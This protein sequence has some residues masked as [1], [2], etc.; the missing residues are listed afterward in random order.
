MRIERRVK[1]FLIVIGM[2]MANSA[3]SQTGLI[4]TTYAATALEL[5]KT[6][7]VLTKGQIAKLKVNNAKGKVGWKTS[8]ERIATVSNTGK[9]TAKA[10]GKALITATVDGKKCT[11]KI[12]IITAKKMNQKACAAYRKMLEKPTLVW[13]PGQGNSSRCNTAE[14]QFDCAD[15]NGDGIKELI[16]Y[17]METYHAE[18]WNRVYTY[19]DGKVKNLGV[20][21]SVDICSD[22]G[23][24]IV[25]AD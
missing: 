5:N 10:V 11:C 6:S 12:E 24:Y 17:W 20:Y 1:I 7:V 23:Y 2:F 21:T 3:I 18:G 22:K 4:E 19:Y 25:S 14:L 13:S 15:I 8:D 9:V 16:L